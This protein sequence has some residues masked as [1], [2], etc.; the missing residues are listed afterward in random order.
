VETSMKKREKKKHTPEVLM[1]QQFA[2]QFE[3]LH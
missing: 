1:Q 3:E 2:V